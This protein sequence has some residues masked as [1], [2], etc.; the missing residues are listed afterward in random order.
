MSQAASSS[1]GLSTSQAAPSSSTAATSGPGS[2]GSAGASNGSSTP[3]TGASNVASSAAGASSS[4]IAS[5][6]A[7]GSSSR[8][9]ASGGGVFVVYI[10][11]TEVFGTRPANSGFGCGASTEEPCEL[12]FA[13]DLSLAEVPAPQ[14][15]AALSFGGDQEVT[16]TDISPFLRVGVTGLTANESSGL[17]VG[18]DDSPD[19]TGFFQGGFTL[20][21]ASGGAVRVN[22]Q[23]VVYECPAY[24]PY[25]CWD[26]VARG[27]PAQDGLVWTDTET[28]SDPGLIQDGT[29][30]RMV[31]SRT[32]PNQDRLEIAVATAPD[33]FGTWTPV[34]ACAGTLG[35]WDES[36]ETPTLVV[37][38]GTYFLYYSGYRMGVSYPADTGLLTSTN[39]VTFTPVSNAPILARTVGGYDQD[40]AY[41]PEV[42][43]HNGTFIMTYVGYCFPAGAGNPC[44]GK[45][46]VHILAA[47]SA[48]GITFNKVPEPLLRTDDGDWWRNGVFKEHSFFKGADDRWYILFTSDLPFVNNAPN[49]VL[50]L[51]VSDGPLGPYE[52]VPGPLLFGNHG[53]AQEASGIIAPDV[54]VTGPQSAVMVY[55]ARNLTQPDLPAFR[56]N[57]ARLHVP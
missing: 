46:G 7:G 12:F 20:N 54:V 53:W 49:D 34:A 44:A 36:R 39:G 18:V 11:N 33:V 38:G 56:I 1:A 48:D 28:L 4:N 51:A 47:T 45:G 6:A 15:V 31:V 16:V 19:A 14:R 5:S 2:G 37:R 43:V 40:A 24:E 29:A 27:G 21:P 52:V 50:G 41:S 30:F 26:K 9:S 13:K 57:G 10:P 22:V 25:T 32:I 8:G 35:A 17:T 23:Y 55:A 42:V 3:S